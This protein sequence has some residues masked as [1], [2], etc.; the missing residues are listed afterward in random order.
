VVGTATGLYRIRKA[1]PWPD[2]ESKSVEQS[3]TDKAGEPK[4]ERTFEN[5]EIREYSWPCVLVLVDKWQLPSD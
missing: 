2:R 4:P 5:S 3:R 1:D